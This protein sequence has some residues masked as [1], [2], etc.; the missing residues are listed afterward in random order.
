MLGKRRFCRVLGDSLRF[1]FPSEAPAAGSEGKHRAEEEPGQGPLPAS[2]LGKQAQEGPRADGA[3]LGACEGEP[4]AG[5]GPGRCRSR[6]D[7]VGEWTPSL[8]FPRNGLEAWVQHPKSTPCVQ[9]HRR[10]AQLRRAKAKLQVGSGGGGQDREG[11]CSPAHS[12][13]HSLP[14]QRQ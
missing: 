7:E 10:S 11:P 6:G 14:S 13:N 8:S 3:G 12:L 4:G 5:A 9:G 1:S 2:S